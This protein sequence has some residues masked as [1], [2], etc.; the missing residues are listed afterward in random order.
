MPSDAPDA[1]AAALER[2]GIRFGTVFVGLFM[3]AWI[4]FWIGGIIFAAAVML[5][6]AKLAIRSANF[7]QVD[8]RVTRCKI[9][10]SHGGE[11]GPSYA[12][13]LAYV[14]EVAGRSYVGTRY[15]TTVVSNNDRG[16]HDRTA[17]ALKPGTVVP[18]YY[19]PDDPSVAL[20]VP[21]VTGGHLFIVLF[22]LPFLAIATLVLGGMSAAA[23]GA[24]TGRSARGAFDAGGM[25]R[26]DTGSLPSLVS[27][28]GMAVAVLGAVGFAGTFLV[29]FTAGFRPPLWFPAGILLLGALLAG[30]LAAKV[31]RK[32][33][34]GAEDVVLDPTRRLVALPITEGRESRV[35]VPYDDVRR[36]EVARKR[37]HRGRGVSG[38]ALYLAPEAAAEAGVEPKQRLT[39]FRSGLKLC[40]RDRRLMEW[41]EEE[42]SSNADPDLPSRSVV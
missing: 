12:L 3:T 20:L 42:L 34:S 29:A 1:A 13:D 17:N 28:A 16:W 11:D 40:D 8:G 18:V 5:P 19:A 32:R 4:T 9:D 30:Y 15:D 23:L 10:V 22:A 36:V 6:G 37:A 38:V 31:Y 14:Y 25:K 21:G 39:P 27:A 41:L 33:S 2:V 26:W 7:P 24:V 35:V